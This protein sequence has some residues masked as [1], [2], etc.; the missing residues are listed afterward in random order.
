MK[1]VFENINSKKVNVIVYCLN[2]TKNYLDKNLKRL[3]KMS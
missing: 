2:N 3:L 1:C